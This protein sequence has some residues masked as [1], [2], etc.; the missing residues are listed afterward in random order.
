[1]NQNASPDE[2]ANFN[3]H[4]NH[5]WDTDGP[6][7]TLHDINP[8]RLDYIASQL[9]GGLQ[10]KRILD[11]GCG[12]GI[13]S[14]AMATAGATVTG[15]DLASDLVACA[16][17][18]AEQSG[19]AL[20][21]SLSYLECSSRDHA[22]D[23]GP[24]YDV[25]TC[26][27]MIEHVPHPDQI[28]QDCANCLKPGGTLVV[29]TLNRNPKSFLYAIVGAEYVLGLIPKGTHHYRQFI[30]PSELNQWATAAGLQA[31]EFK[32][33]GYSPFSR[34]AFITTDLS[35]NYIA[36]FTKPTQ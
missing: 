17:A 34:Q 20:T 30:K 29:S 24:S 35:V 1:M 3:Q 12:A 31:V 25:V 18:H 7:K 16:R 8:T 10:G 4:A 28:I 14:E 15:I 11:V 23:C 6:L 27:E 19:D 2:L 32:G 13:L 9:E 26:L 36:T 21:A 22:S 5:W 33:I